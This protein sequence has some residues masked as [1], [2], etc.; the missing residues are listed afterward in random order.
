MQTHRRRKGAVKVSG[1][2]STDV[3]GGWRSERLA[4]Y[5]GQTLGENT[6]SDSAGVIS[7]SGLSH[8]PLATDV[9][10]IYSTFTVNAGAHGQRP[11]KLTASL[12]IPVVSQHAGATL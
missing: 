1:K 6:Y 2:A 7:D 10:P 9:E 4:V 3:T 12:L 5:R 11:A 8:R